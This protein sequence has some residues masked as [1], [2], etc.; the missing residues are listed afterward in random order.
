MITQIEIDGFKTFSDF[1]VE[2]APFQVLVGPNGSGKSN[3]FD[4]LHLLSRLAEYDL[5]TAFQGLRGSAD[6]QFT[7]YPDGKRVD[8]MRFAV[9]MLVNRNLE[10]DLGRIAELVF[11]RLRYVI[12]IAL[13]KDA[14]TPDQLYITYENLEVI[15]QETDIWSKRYN[16]ASSKYLLTKNEG[17]GHTF[18]SFEQ[19]NS[20]IAWLDVH[21]LDGDGKIGDN[22]RIVDETHPFNPQR[23]KRTMLSSSALTLSLHAIAVREELHLLQLLHLNPENLRQPSAVSNPSHLTAD[24]GNLPTVLARMQ[25]ENEFALTDVSLDIANLVPNLTTIELKRDDI[26]NEYSIWANYSDAPSISSYTMSDGTLCLLALA[27][28]TNDPEFHG[29]LCLEEPEN[30]VDSL[31]LKRIAH[32]LKE[33]ATDFTDSEQ[34]DEPLRQVLITTHSPTFISLPE[35]LNSLL[36]AHMVTRVEPSSSGK[37]TMQVTEIASVIENDNATAISA[38]SLDQIK[39]YLDGNL[40]NAARAT[41]E[42]R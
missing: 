27:T 34:G 24:G 1:K 12:E 10:D 19:K 38:Y 15:P 30:S 35:I 40:L 6:D 2:L 3:L 13:N 17:D 21:Y 20:K 29:I 39:K 7:K 16:L 14:N 25:A 28:I 22:V 11:T 5:L 23:V 36:F 42:K 26:R 18:F 41:L 9:E 4:A 33:L 32:L 8:K 37:P 31:Y